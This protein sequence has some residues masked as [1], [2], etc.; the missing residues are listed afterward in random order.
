M[1]R[2]GYRHK[3]S[4]NIHYICDGFKQNTFTAV[5]ELQAWCHN[6]SGK[7]EYLTFPFNHVFE[8]QICGWWLPLPLSC[9]TRERASER[10]GADDGYWLLIYHISPH[11][12]GTPINIQGLEAWG[13]DRGQAMCKRREHKDKP[14]RFIN[15]AWRFVTTL[16]DKCLLEARGISSVI[17]E[18]I[19]W[20][21]NDFHLCSPNLLCISKK[22]SSFMMALSWLELKK[23]KQ[24]DDEKLY[25]LFTRKSDRYRPESKGI[26]CASLEL[27][28]DLSQMKDDGE[29]F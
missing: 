8:E 4:E 15:A 14:P 19:N 23:T 26:F 29:S 5:V 20:F 11:H 1:C 27:S 16:G 18:H 25:F 22:Q 28:L 13:L 12:S 2:S 6:F 21:C 9:D 17:M 24:W 10:E 3:R 7:I